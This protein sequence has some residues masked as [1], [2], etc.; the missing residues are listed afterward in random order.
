MGFHVFCDSHPTLLCPSSLTVEGEDEA[1]SPRQ[2]G[3]LG[4]LPGADRGGEQWGSLLQAVLL[5]P[6]AEESGGLATKQVVMLAIAQVECPSVVTPV[7]AEVIKPSRLREEAGNVWGRWEGGTNCEGL[8]CVP[9]KDV[10]L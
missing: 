3:V 5:F 4:D 7:E 6:E 8:L 1:R 10:R 9:H 2:A